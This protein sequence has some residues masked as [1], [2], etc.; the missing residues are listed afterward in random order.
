MAKAA[1]S[2]ADQQQHQEHNTGLCH[3]EGPASLI[4]PPLT[5]ASEHPK[6]RKFSAPAPL[7]IEGISNT[8][9]VATKDSAQAAQQQQKEDE[10]IARMEE[11]LQSLIEEGQA[12]LSSRVELYDL[13]ENEITMR[14]AFASG[15]KHT[16]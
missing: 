8:A 4:T 11:R 14:K 3:N 15:A 2:L 5:P 12:A 9:A 6:R 7:K 13:D 16:I 1:S 10:M